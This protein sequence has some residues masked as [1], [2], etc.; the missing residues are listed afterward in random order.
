MYRL[1]Y[2]VDRLLPS[3]GKRDFGLRFIEKFAF[4]ATF[5]LFYRLLDDALPHPVKKSNNYR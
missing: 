2:Q 3:F 4:H 1:P 5:E